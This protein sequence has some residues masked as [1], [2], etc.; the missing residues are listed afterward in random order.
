MHSHVQGAL[1]EFSSVDMH[2][3]YAYEWSSPGILG[4]VFQID[5]QSRCPKFDFYQ[6]TEEGKKVVDACNK[7]NRQLSRHQHPSCYRQDLYHSQMEQVTI[8][9][10]M[11]LELHNFTAIEPAAEATNS[12]DI[13]RSGKQAT[14]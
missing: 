2:M 11:P 13:T 4:T 1:C 9:M 6:L 8:T 10:S 14:M 3:Q 12:T 5:E 7:S